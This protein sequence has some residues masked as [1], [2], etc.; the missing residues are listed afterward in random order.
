[1]VHTHTDTHTDTHTHTHA[2]THTQTDTHTDTHTHTHTETQKHAHSTRI[3]HGCV[4]A[5]RKFVRCLMY[6]GK[7]STAEKIL[8][9]TFTIIKTNE[10]QRCVHLPSKYA[11]SENNTH[12]HSRTSNLTCNLNQLEEGA[13]RQ[14]PQRGMSPQRVWGAANHKCTHTHTHTHSLSLTLN[15]TRTTPPPLVSLVSEPKRRCAKHAL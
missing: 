4:C 2:Q 9:N 6:S 13:C 5:C 15:F 12:S 14:H 3:L 10:L 11:L 7:K 1:M 8:K